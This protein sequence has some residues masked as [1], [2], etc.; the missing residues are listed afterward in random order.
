MITTGDKNEK[1]ELEED[2]QTIDKPQN[3]NKMHKEEVRRW[4]FL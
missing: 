1:D 4:I 3:P 2:I